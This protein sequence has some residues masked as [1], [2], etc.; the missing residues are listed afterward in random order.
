[1][2][3]RPWSSN[4]R[5]QASTAPGIVTACGPCFGNSLKPFSRYQS[6][7]AAFGARP[8]PLKAI[9]LPSPFG[10]WSTKQSPPMAVDCGS[11]TACTAAAQ[12]AAS[13]ALP[14]ERSIWMAASVASGCE[15]AAMA[16]VARTGERPGNWKSRMLVL[17]SLYQ[18]PRPKSWAADNKTIDSTIR[19][20]EMAA[21]VGSI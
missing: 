2:P 3:L 6:T 7:V 17:V 10:Q 13:M 4:S 19:Q 15:V 11:T 12:T 20:V 9:T 14:P 1:M 16:S 8:E 18:R 21:M 5:H